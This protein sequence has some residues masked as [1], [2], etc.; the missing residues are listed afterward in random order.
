MRGYSCRRLKGIT[1]NY[2]NYAFQ[3]IL[4]E[5]NAKPNKIWVDKDSKFYSRLMKSWL[6]D[7]DMYSVHNKGKPVVA[8]RF[9]RTLKNNIFQYQKM[10]I[11]IN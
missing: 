2:V 10:C 11:L 4:N 7:N 1:L 6:Q 9:I 3:I 5:S 8:E